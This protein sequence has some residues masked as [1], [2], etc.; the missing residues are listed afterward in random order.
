MIFMLACP[1]MAP[2]RD[3]RRLRRELK[4]VRV[5]ICIAC[6]CA[7]SVPIRPAPVF[8]NGRSPAVPA[9]AGVFLLSPLWV[10]DPMGRHGHCNPWGAS[11]AP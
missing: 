11:E 9:Q 5:M 2:P 1:A 4:T 8:Q 3:T 10:A 6:R 7:G